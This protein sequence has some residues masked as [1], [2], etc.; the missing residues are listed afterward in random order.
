MNDFHQPVA[1]AAHAGGRHESRVW[2]L[3]Q[4]PVP[5]SAAL[6]FV[7]FFPL[8]MEYAFSEFVREGELNSRLGW[9]WLLLALLRVVDNKYFRQVVLGIFLVSGCMDNLYA[10]TFGGV[11]TTASFE[12]MALTDTDEALGF[13][14]AYAAFGNLSLLAFYLLGGV[15]LIKQT[16]IPAG[17]GRLHNTVMVLGLVMMAVVTYRVAIM[18]SYYDTVPGFLGTIPTYMSS[19]E[20]IAQEISQRKALVANSTVAVALDQAARPQTYVVII[21]ESLTRQHMGLYG[22]SRDTTPRLAAMGK[23]LVVFQDVISAYVQTHPSLKGALMP[24]VRA[25]SGKDA[26]LSMVDVAN[27]AGFKT[28]WISNQQPQR[29]TISAIAA[30]ADEEKFISNDFHGVVVRRYDGFLL[31][32]IAAALRDPAPRKAVFV[33]LMGSHLQYDNRFPESFR[34]FTSDDVRGYRPKLSARQI[35]YINSYDNS[36]RYTD[37]V[38]ASILELLKGVARQQPQAAA[39]LFFSDHGEEVFESKDFLGHGPDGVTPAMLEIPFIAW[40]SPEYRL[41]RPQR[42]RNLERHARAPYKLDAAFDTAMDLMGIKTPLLDDA[43]SLASAAF[44]PRTRVVYGK[45]YDQVFRASATQDRESRV[46]D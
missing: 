28:W 8:G 1:E 20:D 21:G 32:Y 37:D 7:L 4:R 17:R 3:L 2:R 31:P 45:R 29:Q 39:A 40:L 24:T 15:Y 23:E 18:K 6:L 30:M 27:K 35:R 12:A 34:H 42:T 25:G 41:L 11:F 13:V 33:H 19:H 36:V 38:V 26:A 16:R 46:Y 9:F 44:R 22:Y 14:K 43:Q 5:L 10:V